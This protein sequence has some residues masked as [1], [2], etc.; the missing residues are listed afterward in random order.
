MTSLSQGQDSRQSQVSEQQ[1]RLM[2][3]I[4]ILHKSIEV[5][6]AKLES[7]LRP[8]NPRVDEKSAEKPALVILAEAFRGLCKDAKN[9]RFVIEDLIERLEL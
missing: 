4:G 2:H 8:S 3:E 1:E 6:A 7:V 5:L 9:A